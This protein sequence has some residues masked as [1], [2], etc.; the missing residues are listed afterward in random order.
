MAKETEVCEYMTRPLENVTAV[1]FDG[2]NVA[3]VLNV[4]GGKLLRSHHMTFGDKQHLAYIHINCGLGQFTVNVGDWV[5]RRSW[6]IWTCRDSEFTE[7]FE[8]PKR[9]AEPP[10]TKTLA[11][12]VRIVVPRDTNAGAVVEGV[13]AAL[14][15]SDYEFDHGT[16]DVKLGN[17]FG[18][19]G[20]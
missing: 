16:I 14:F 12:T 15:A 9:Q 3:A 20:S 13:K 4:T 10:P 7:T 11:M 8:P 6:R 17:H 2:T 19:D 1:R 5:V 18:N